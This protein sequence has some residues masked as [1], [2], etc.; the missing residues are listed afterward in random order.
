MAGHSRAAHGAP[1]ADAFGLETSTEGLETVCGWLGVDAGRFVPQERD[2]ADEI[3][4]H[5]AGL[6][7]EA[8]AARSARKQAQES[9][10]MTTA[11]A[12]L[13][14]KLVGRDREA[15][16]RAA[17]KAR[18]RREAAADGSSDEG[19]SKHTAVGQG[20]PAAAAPAEG[21][22]RR[23]KRRRGDADAAGLAAAAPAAAPATGLAEAD[24]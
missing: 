8:L 2:Y 19:V 17:R 7:A 10:G 12:A 14:R 5:R 3:R 13:R 20:A 1:K 6:G 22:R 21:K 9:A 23:K 11:D 24:D 15:A 18:L 4:P 16:E